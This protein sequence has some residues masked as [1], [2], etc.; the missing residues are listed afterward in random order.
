MG[1]HLLGG[2][3]CRP[4]GHVTWVLLG[5]VSIAAFY[6]LLALIAAL[7]HSGAGPRAAHFPIPGISIL[8]P[9]YGRDAGFYSAIRSHAIQQNPEFEILFGV[10]AIDDPASVDI[11]RLISEFPSVRVRLIV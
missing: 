6:Q 9:V 7:V 11:Q 2:L 10:H 1:G 4:A 8:K 5:I 3:R